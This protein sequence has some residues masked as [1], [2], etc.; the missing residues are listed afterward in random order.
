MSNKNKELQ[1]KDG[2][3]S[4]I[5][6][7]LNRSTVRVKEYYYQILLKNNIK[8]IDLLNMN[9]EGSE[10]VVLWEMIKNKQIKELSQFKFSFTEY[11]LL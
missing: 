3:S 8:K 1:N 5:G 7:S 9:I 6:N 10:Y 2:E 11:Y 4:S